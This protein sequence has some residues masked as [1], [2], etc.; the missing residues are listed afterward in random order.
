MVWNS[1]RSTLRAPSNLNDAVI[2]DTI[3]PI[4]LLN[5]KTNRK[6]IFRKVYES[7]QHFM[8]IQK[9]LWNIRKFYENSEQFTKIQ[10]IIW[11]FRKF[12]E[13]SEKFLR[14]RNFYEKSEIFMKNQKIL[15]KFRKV[16]EF[17]ILRQ[18]TRVAEKILLVGEIKLN[19]YFRWFY[20]SRPIS[21]YK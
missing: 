7:S 1:V 12:N 10:N 5:K 9:I 4:N 19:L 13:N 15:W 16:F 17:Y 3:W 2:L 8:K 18:V 6:F 20:F 11:K 14:I 21:F